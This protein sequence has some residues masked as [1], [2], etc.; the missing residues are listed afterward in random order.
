MRTSEW[1]APASES[2]SSIMPQVL[3]MD[4]AVPRL[5]TGVLAALREG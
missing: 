1:W 2:S 5:P 4:D 3:D